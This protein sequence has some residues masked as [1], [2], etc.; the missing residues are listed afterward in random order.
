MTFSRKKKKNANEQTNERNERWTNKSRGNY[1]TYQVKLVGPK[2][3]SFT[4]IFSFLKFLNEY[5]TPIL[6]HE[7]VYFW[8]KSELWYFVQ[9]WEVTGCSFV[10]L[11]SMVDKFF[12]SLL[13]FFWNILTFFLPFNPFHPSVTSHI[14]RSF[15]LQTK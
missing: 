11:S 10:V 5:L 8:N 1:R 2:R 7:K 12:L 6:L 9:T 3:C 4:D 13:I 15:A 14:N